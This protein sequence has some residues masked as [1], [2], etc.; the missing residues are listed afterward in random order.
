MKQ[1]IL[2]ML[3]NHVD[4]LI[5]GV[6]AIVA[7]AILW[8]FVIG[9]PYG[10]Q[11]NRATCSPGSI[12]EKIKE[13]AVRLEQRINGDATEKPV[14]YK[15]NKA[16]KYLAT[17]GSTVEVNDKVIIPINTGS[18]DIE[19]KRFYRMPAIPAVAGVDAQAIR[20]AVFVPTEKVDMA[21]SYEQAKTEVVDIDFITVEAS[22]DTSE[23]YKNF[24]QSFV[25]GVTADYKDEDLAV[26]VFASVALERQ[27]LGEDGQWSDWQ[28]VS[29]PNIDERRE[30]FVVPGKANEID[31][32]GIDVLVMTFEEFEI[33]KD[34]LQPTSYEI[35]ASNAEW[36]TPAYHKELSEMIA[37]EKRDAE[38]AAS[39]KSV[40]P[41]PG[42]QRVNELGNRRRNPRDKRRPTGASRRDRKIED[43]R[44]DFDFVKLTKDVDLSIMKDPLVF[45]GYDADIEPLK[46]YR[47]RIRLGVFNPTAGKG[48]F[49]GAA[50]EFKDDVVLW[51]EYSEVTEPI[52]ID[53]MVHFFP[54]E[55]AKRTKA[56]TIQVSKFNGGKWQSEEFEVKVGDSI[57]HEIEIEEEE[58][59]AARRVRTKNDDEIKKIDFASGAILVDVVTS[60]RSVAGGRPYQE[61]LYSENGGVIKHLGVS[62]R[63]WSKSMLSTFKDIAAQQ[64]IVV[65]IFK[66][67][68]QS[69]GGMRPGGTEGYDDMGDMGAMGGYGEL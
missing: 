45:W 11:V 52:A 41:K 68:G 10:G 66:T 1:K 13:T 7:L 50:T 53:P 29:R 48:W 12:D 17:M 16:G 69:G 19:D 61:I 35:A 23:L 26:P 44:A 31:L 34:L 58:D 46:S 24:R 18:S 4:K 38:M 30:M 5:L 22:F 3:E 43:I 25:T 64:D 32:G 6:I 8:V 62:K 33:Q 57:G 37:K 20:T 28:A 2:D 65:E 51:S 49:S 55:L 36:M 60:R 21:M 54:L 14:K 9:T 40:R 67:R 56:A 59:T 27:V 42:R 39:G 63:N 47:Y 15:D